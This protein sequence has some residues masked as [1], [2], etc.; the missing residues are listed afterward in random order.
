PGV[1]PK[2]QKLEPLLPAGSRMLVVRGPVRADGYDWYEVQAASKDLSMFGWVAAG[3]DAEAW[4]EPVD[5]Q[6]TDDLDEPALWI[7]EPI[8]F[9]VCY[10]DR[11][12]NVRVRA[13]EPDTG[14]VD[15]PA[16]PYTGD[17]VPCSPRPGWLFESREFAYASPGAPVG[18]LAVAAHGSVA[19]RLADASRFDILSLTIS[20]D[21]PEA[22]ACRIVD[23]RGRN[24]ISR[25]EAITRC[26][27]TR[28]VRDVSWNAAEIPPTL[29]TLARVVANVPLLDSPDGAV[30]APAL[31]AGTEIVV[32]DESKG[33]N[34]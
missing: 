10:G 12:V 7:V 1:G 16:C 21:A 27:L 14:D 20:M 2:S 24:L 32:V 6:C 4:I 25:D 29:Q 30:A 8:D 33:E 31:A 26:R 9:L 17:D 19:K 23:R 22:G 11:P 13:V 15:V 3:L 5:P 18:G 34:G 28:V